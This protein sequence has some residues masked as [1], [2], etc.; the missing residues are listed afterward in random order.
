MGRRRQWLMTIQT[1]A[2][3]IA[4]LE[5]YRPHLVA[6][7]RYVAYHIAL[8]NGT[9]HNRQ[10]RDEMV[11]MDRMPKGDERWM[12]AIYHAP[13]VFESTGRKQEVYEASPRTRGGGGGGR[14]IVIWRLKPGAPAPPRPSHWQGYRPTYFPDEIDAEVVRKALIEME[15]S[16]NLSQAV[17]GVLAAREAG[18]TV[19]EQAQS[20][21]IHDLAPKTGL[22]IDEVR[23]YGLWA[24]WK[25]RNS[26][27]RKKVP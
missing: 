10:V 20:R 11:A 12:G 7:G 1:T 2:E 4:I 18:N 19:E 15:A 8:R 14:P 27:K 9:V 13:K 23:E 17:R 3:A 26:K 24:A 16:F 5:K 6:L 25:A 22:Y 21:R